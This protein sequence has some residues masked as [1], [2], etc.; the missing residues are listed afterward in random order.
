[1]VGGVGQVAR[2]LEVRA[3]PPEV[4]EDVHDAAAGA[5]LLLVEV[6]GEVDLGQPSFATIFK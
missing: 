6:A 5:D 2:D 4:D 1:M 3:R